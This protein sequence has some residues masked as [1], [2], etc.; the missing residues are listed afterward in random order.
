MVNIW[1]YANNLPRI[2]LVDLNKRVYVG[3]ILA[4][5]DAQ[6]TFDDD[7]DLLE[8]E[9]DSGEIVIFHPEEIVS[10]KVLEQ[11]QKGSM[12]KN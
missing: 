7:R 10:I 11:R 5:L 9:L 4:V 6:E 3:D 8:L 2:R 1:D 12:K